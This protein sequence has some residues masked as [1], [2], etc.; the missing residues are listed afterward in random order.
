MYLEKQQINVDSTEKDDSEFSMKQCS[1]MNQIHD[2]FQGDGAR[3]VRSGNDTTYTDGEADEKAPPYISLFWNDWTLSKN[4]FLNP[5][6]ILENQNFL[7][8]SRNVYHL[9]EECLRQFT[10]V[11]NKSIVSNLS[12][13]RF[14]VEQSWEPQ[15][16]YLENSHF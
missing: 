2:A 7:Q 1:H 14:R 12:H 13:I 5:N 11:N 4:H 9:L 8:N 10:N 16:S 3:E 15:S 6:K